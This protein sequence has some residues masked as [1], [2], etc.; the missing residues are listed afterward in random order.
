MQGVPMSDVKVKLKAKLQEPTVEVAGRFE[1]APPAAEAPKVPE[2]SGIS[3]APV[4]APMPR[5]AAAFSKAEVDEMVRD[6]I[7]DMSKHEFSTPMPAD[8]Q[9][10]VDARANT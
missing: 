7:A 9:T 1:A 8:L 5:Q 4:P 2:N 3:A 6:G 10:L